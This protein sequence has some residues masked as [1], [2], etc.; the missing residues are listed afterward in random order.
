MI[1]KYH[2]QGEKSFVTDK[3]GNL[4]SDTFQGC[5]DVDASGKWAGWF[6]NLS[7]PAHNKFK[8]GFGSRAVAARWV[9]GKL[10]EVGVE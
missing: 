1:I 7:N 8:L 6:F 5:V 2:R 9:N 10:R 3:F 4:L